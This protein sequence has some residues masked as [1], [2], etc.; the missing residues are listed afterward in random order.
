MRHIFSVTVCPESDHR[1]FIIGNQ[2][3]VL[4]T[5]D[6]S[7]FCVRDDQYIALRMKQFVG[8]SMAVCPRVIGEER[9]TFAPIKSARR[10]RWKSTSSTSAKAAAN[11]TARRLFKKRLPGIINVRTNGSQMYAFRRVNAAYGW[12]SYGPITPAP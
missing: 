6:S 2:E 10:P 11:Q 1:A 9:V 8:H 4:P 5:Q 3:K 12:E 7:Q